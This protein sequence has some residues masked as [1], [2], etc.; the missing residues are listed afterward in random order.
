MWGPERS[1]PLSLPGSPRVACSPCA[2]CSHPA[3][4]RRSLASPTRSRS[5]LFVTIG[6]LSHDGAVSLGGYAGDALP[7][8]AGWFGAALAFGTYRRRT[9]GSLL[10]AWIVGIPAGVLIRALVLGHPLDGDQV[11]F[12]IVTLVF[13]ALFVLGLRATLL[14]VPPRAAAG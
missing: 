3:A 1:G 2:C 14:L 5:S 8:L 7:I 4:R 12:L 10:G 9:L 13:S 11:A 6:L